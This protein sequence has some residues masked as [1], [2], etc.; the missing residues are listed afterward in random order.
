M[1]KPKGRHRQES[2]LREISGAPEVANAAPDADEED[3][4]GEVQE[5][6]IPLGEND[7]VVLRMVIGM[8]GQLLDF[9]LVQQVLDGGRWS[10]V[11]RY[12][13]SH[14]EVHEHRFVKRQR[15]TIKKEIC[16]L[17]EIED[18]YKVAEDVIF[19]GWE[20]NRRRYFDG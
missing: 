8:R 5:Y 9:A 11:V 18:G 17:T 12:D 1:T 15:S 13:C 19:D 6:K 14:G 10:D 2:R 4:F 16:G 7:R 20:E 3:E